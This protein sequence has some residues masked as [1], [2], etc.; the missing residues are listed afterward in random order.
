M[1]RLRYIRGRLAALMALAALLLGL[2]I[3]AVLLDTTGALPV[4]EWISKHPTAPLVINVNTATV[5]ELQQLN[6]MTKELAQSIV[7]YRTE[8]V[9]FRS[10]EEVRYLPDVTDYLYLTWYPY[11][12]V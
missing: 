7:D 2:V 4:D 10:V 6:G 5:E 1:S 8:F 11:L 12:T 9:R 3:G